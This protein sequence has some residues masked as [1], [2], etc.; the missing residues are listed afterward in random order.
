MRLL[1]VFIFAALIQG[2]ASSPSG[3]SWM[4]ADFNKYGKNYA[5][6]PTERL[7]IAQTKQEVVGV[8]GS[9][10]KVVEAGENYEVIS[11]Q[12]WKSIAGPDY[13]ESTL[14]LRIIEGKL[15]NWK[16]S[17]DTVEVVPRTW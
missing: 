8:L 11:Y 7:S 17:S 9:N 10:Y 1:L 15:K 6:F 4:Y 2:C 12:K 16:I 14:Y 3:S 13:V 5:D